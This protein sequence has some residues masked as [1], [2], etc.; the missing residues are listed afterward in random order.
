MNKGDICVIGGLHSTDFCV[1]VVRSIDFDGEVYY[2]MKDTLRY[3]TSY[4]AK[5]IGTLISEYV[6]TAL[7]VPFGFEGGTE[8][9]VCTETKV[10]EL[11]RG[12]WK[13]ITQILYNS[14]LLKD[15]CR[16]NHDAIPM[17]RELWEKS[18]RMKCGWTVG[19]IVKGT[20]A[21]AYAI[22][23]QNMLQGEIVAI[24]SAEDNLFKVK[25]LAHATRPSE[26]GQV[27]EVNAGSPNNRYFERIGG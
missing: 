14:T 26:I 6:C 2:E 5:A 22:T 8:V 23:N 27:Y 10:Y 17:N 3:G 18:P 25:I 15:L 24:I 4:N 19:D 20:S 12:T 16:K 21:G 7:K 11:Q 13:E 9:Y 1:G